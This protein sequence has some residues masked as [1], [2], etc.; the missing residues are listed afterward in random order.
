[1]RAA[2]DAIPT[3]EADGG[4]PAEDGLEDAE[5]L[6][7]SSIYAE[8]QGCLDTLSDRRSDRG[9]SLQRRCGQT[10]IWADA[11]DVI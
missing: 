2:F 5:K 8:S 9:A 1:V 10:H 6:L 4:A 11:H 3:A 7:T